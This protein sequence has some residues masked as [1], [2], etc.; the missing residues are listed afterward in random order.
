MKG[1]TTAIREHIADHG[2]TQAATARALGIGRQ[3]F[4]RKLNGHGDFSVSELT[5]LAEI[6]GTTVADLMCRADQIAH[7]DVSP[8]TAG[9]AIKD[10]RDDVVILQARRIDFGGEAA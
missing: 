10:T 8:S 1:L 5:R 3:T 4:S 2:L 9:Y 7:A 6:L